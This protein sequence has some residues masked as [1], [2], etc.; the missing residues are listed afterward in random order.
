MT[1]KMTIFLVK[2][3]KKK[4]EEENVPK[5]AK[6]HYERNFENKLHLILCTPH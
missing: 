4:E 6:K 5:N 1:K 3:E 2:N